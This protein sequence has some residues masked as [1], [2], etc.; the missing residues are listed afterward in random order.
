[1][2]D[3]ND[4]ALFLCCV[5]PFMLA[6]A[7]L[8]KQNWTKL[9]LIG[10]SLCS[11][12]MIILTQSR[13]GFLALLAVTVSIILFR[14][15]RLDQKPASF[16]VR[17]R[18]VLLLAVAAVLLVALAPEGARERLLTI[19]EISSDY[20]VAADDKAGR[21][22]IWTRG[23]AYL[24][25]HPWG[26]GVGSY[27]VIDMKQGGQFRDA[28]NAF[29]QVAVEIGVIGL[30]V[31]LWCFKRAFGALRRLTRG[32]QS[33]KMAMRRT[34]TA[35][36]LHAYSQALLLSMIAFCV[37]GFFLSAG[38]DNLLFLFF[39]MI[40]H[41]ERLGKRYVSTTLRHSGFEFSEV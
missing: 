5:L 11:V 4:L 17:A 36:T 3:Q 14:G 40:A 28:H 21:I 2:L 12:L 1:M 41:V 33:Q 24:S 15:F 16:R 26:S 35:V 27:R 37:A 6:E 29:V 13:G 7:S 39:A 19:T 23:L 38:Y 20:N 30:I 18:R 10:A 25:G 32:L 31:Y 9:I 22:A 34:K 8:A